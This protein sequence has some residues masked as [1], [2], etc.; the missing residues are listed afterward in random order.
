MTFTPYIVP[1]AL[2]AIVSFGLAIYAWRRRANPGA[3]SFTVLM[4]AVSLWALAYSFELAST[5]LASKFFWA[6]VK[7]VAIV[8]VPVAW[9]TFAVEYSG[10]ARRLTRRNLILLSI[11]PVITV[12]LVLTSDFHD[13]MWLQVRVQNSGP[14][15]SLES[16]NGL[17]FGVHLAYSYLLLLGAT[18]LLLIA[19]WQSWSSLYRWQAV[20]LLIAMLAPWIGYA[21]FLFG[22]KPVPGLDPTFVGFA[23]GA[24]SIAV[25][26]V[27]FGLFEFIPVARRV[28]VDSMADGMVVLDKQDRIVDINAAGRTIIDRSAA[29]ALGQPIG[30]ILV[31]PDGTDLMAPYRDLTDGRVE[32]SLGL[33]RAQRDYEVHISPLHDQRNR[34]QGRLL[35][36]RDITDRKEAERA[37]MAQRQL[38]QNLVAVARATTEQPTLKATLQS[39]LDVAVS[40]TKAERGSVFLFDD[41]GV[42]THGLW[43]RQSASLV[44]QRNVVGQVMK[45]GLAGWVVRHRQAVL[46]ADTRKDDRWLTLLGEPE[47]ARSVL[48]VPILSG[49]ATLGLITL[50]HTQPAYFAQDDLLLMQA[51]ADQV[52]LAL[53]NARLYDDQRRLARQQAILYAALRAVGGHLQPATVANIAVEAI[54]RLTGWTAVAILVPSRKHDSLVVRA[55]AG[56]LST[57]TG[58]SIPMA[59]SISGRSFVTGQ[60]QLVRDVTMDRQYF[61]GHESIRSELTVP[62]RHGQ[63]LLGVLDVES[64]Q[65]NAFRAEDI[66]LAES[67]ADA[68]A[69]SL[70]NARL[71]RIIEDERSRLHALIESSRDGVILVG[72]DQRVLVMNAPAKEILNLPGRPEDWVNHSL[73]QMLFTLQTHAPD[74][75]ES[76]F[77][78][79]QL[80]NV[81]DSA[82]SEG[83]IEVPPRTIH[84]LNLPVKAGK[85]PLG[86]LLALRDVTEAR[87]LEQMREDLTH[88]MVHDLRNPLNNILGAQELLAMTDS[89]TDEQELVLKVARDGTQKMLNLVN[90]ILDISRL[91]SGRM[92]L[93]RQPIDIEE[94]IA[95]ALQAQLPLATKKNIS[96]RDD[97]PP[98]LPNVWGDPRLVER[99]LQNLVDNAL[100]F[101]PEGGQIEVTAELAQSKARSD[102]QDSRLVVSV[103]DT[104]P[105][106]P[107]E[108]TDRMF[109]KFTTGR[110]V[111]SGSGLG[112][113][114]CKMAI[115]ALGGRI[116]VE[117]APGQGARFKFTLPK[118]TEQKKADL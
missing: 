49:A 101:T 61:P 3:V 113:T 67:L 103:C 118:V 117:S 62:L 79:L 24:L 83:E 38:F 96:L 66:R 36:L 18:I 1:P 110:H 13:L 54:A 41:A 9:L 74:A 42:V 25:A 48:S 94:S 70:D 80:L 75:S 93:N 30:E 52:A 98:N 43:S 89:L 2:T 105:G 108:L 19:V 4:L 45:K 39:A 50:E 28:V 7:Y 116:W 32:I 81:G 10:E 104:G 12:L 69:L 87:L 33:D 73:D 14:F 95:A 15:T 40:L 29:G 82:P 114:F 68:I 53:Q 100:K 11:I 91:E 37:L 86:R 47:A 85:T 6:R 109:Q 106:I 56:L 51:S 107:P 102:T 20:A 8:T 90:A 112:L 72:M 35:I 5:D 55:A 16:D 31:G 63:R 57:A 64:D 44:R 23:V 34:L 92:H 76:S 99:I 17:W 59:N 27:Y 65:L 97:V 46:I 111:A 26:V 60:T 22:P 115:E 78:D 71:F 77:T 88:T 21:I 58:M 84:W